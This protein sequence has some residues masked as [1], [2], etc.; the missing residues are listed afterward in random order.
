VTNP[1]PAVT[2]HGVDKGTESQHCTRTRVTRDRDTAVL[3]IPVTNPKGETIYFIKKTIE[4]VHV[5]QQ[6]LQEFGFRLH[7][8]KGHEE[9]RQLTLPV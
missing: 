3:R 4:G 2:V 9:S 5:T 6:E 7:L 1:L 8:R